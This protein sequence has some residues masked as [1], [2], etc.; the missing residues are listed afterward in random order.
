MADYGG[1]RP[2]FTYNREDD[3]K[4]QVFDKAIQALQTFGAFMQ[5]QAQ[6]AERRKDAI[7]SA[8]IDQLQKL[9][10]DVNIQ[11]YFDNENYRK[12]KNEEKQV[13]M[14]IANKAYDF[15]PEKG[16]QVLSSTILAYRSV[17][18]QDT[19]PLVFT[20]DDIEQ[21][22]S[23]LIKG[24]PDIN[25]P[26]IMDLSW[27][28]VSG[29]PGMGD[30]LLRLGILQDSELNPE[31]WEEARHHI[32]ERFEYFSVSVKS[33]TAAMGK[34]KNPHFASNQTEIDQIVS[35]KIQLAQQRLSFISEQPE[36]KAYQNAD[37][38][39]SGEKDGIIG[40]TLD[41]GEQ[42]ARTKEGL[43]DWETWSEEN[44]NT[45]MIYNLSIPHLADMAASENAADREYFTNLM[46]GID[47]EA[48][49]RG[50]TFGLTLRTRINE[51]N[52]GLQLFRGAN[53]GVEIFDQME[54]EDRAKKTMN[55]IDSFNEVVVPLS[56]RIAY[57]QAVVTGKLPANIDNIESKYLRMDGNNNIIGIDTSAAQKDLLEG[58][59]KMNEFVTSVDDGYVRNLHS[60]SRAH[61]TRSFQHEIKKHANI[62]IKTPAENRIR[63]KDEKRD[64]YLDAIHLLEYDNIWRGAK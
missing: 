25:E 4:I 62:I 46:K 18:P 52:T 54:L 7:I 21:V 8:E 3:P 39:W 5:N 63:K 44:P 47:N 40:L 13:R 28:E 64:A 57:L 26:A 1:M 31:G 35:Q 10:I 30:E 29:I 60:V 16:Q 22:R 41:D 45:V 11:D 6:P 42:Y 20:G 33:G 50:D 51:Y 58:L 15:V 12:Q 56:Q 27:E 43:I 48:S 37:A 32:P 9:N 14:N 17:F 38:A 2:T 23:I 55:D 59:A 36:V 49:V 19:T 34:T 61:I 53:R 24:D